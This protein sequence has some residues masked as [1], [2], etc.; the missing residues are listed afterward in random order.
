MRI[1]FHY[2]IPVYVKDGHIYTAGYLGLFLDSLAVHVQ[3]LVLFM[4]TPLPNEMFRMDYQLRST[5]VRLIS[6]GPH[7]SVPHRLLNSG[8][9]MRKILPDL[10]SLDLLL[11][12]CPTPLLPTLSR[13]RKL[14]KAFLIV[15]DYQKSAKDLK[16][17]FLR[18][19]AIQLWTS[20]NKWQQDK[21]IRNSLVL[22]NNRLIFNELS[23]KV[24]K[25]HE[26]KTTTLQKADFFYREDT[27]QN[28]CINILYAGR[29]DLSKG[30]QEMIGSLSRLRSAGIQVL[31]HFVGWEDKNGSDVTELLRQ[32]S[33]ELGVSDYVLFHGKKKVGAELNSFYRMADIYVIG[34]K[35]NEGFPRTIWEAFANGT[36]VVASA[37]GSIPLFLRDRIDA[38]LMKPGS[39]D[40][41]TRSLK[42]VIDDSALR[43]SLI[44]QAYD[45][46]KLNT[47]ENQASIMMKIIEDDIRITPHE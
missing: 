8:K 30:L 29:M 26:I 7:N 33:V 31:L 27:C 15:G 16:Q 4:H 42:L 40:E 11:I 3:E 25:L 12:R 14:Q 9:I 46:A 43:K 44:K 18:K 41:M 37:V 6:M 23:G 28:K 19:K 13:V 32:Q 45:V 5:N 35:E 22:V 2:H 20:L 21:A 24:K 38:V 39:V 36:P 10:Q 34:S 47:L 1:G 17:P